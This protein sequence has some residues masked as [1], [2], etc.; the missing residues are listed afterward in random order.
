MNLTSKPT[1]E[2]AEASPRAPAHEQVYRK[3]RAQI[4]F[5]EMAPGQAVTIQG[6]AQALGVGMTPV[7][8]AIRKLIS[9]GALVFQGN[10]RVSVPQLS[11]SDMEQLVYL[12]ITMESELASRASKRISNAAIGDLDRIDK[13]LD[14]SISAGD[15][16]GYLANNYQFHQRLYEQA[17]APILTD[18]VNRVWLRFGPS[19][20]VVCGWYGTQNL[21]DHHKELLEALRRRDH[22]AATH[23]IVKDVEQGIQQITEVLRSDTDSIDTQ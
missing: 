1:A 9:D 17:D 20:R 19:L 16:V 23:A 12:R 11:T 5:G 22:E 7:R 2:P 15:V 6:L 13:L 18:L 3:L 8:E 10:R 21:R 4:L 14:Q